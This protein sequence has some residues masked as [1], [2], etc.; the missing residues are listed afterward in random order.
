[1]DNTCI[2]TYLSNFNS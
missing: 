1:M 2:L